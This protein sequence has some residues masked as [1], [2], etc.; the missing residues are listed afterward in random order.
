MEIVVVGSPE[1]ETRV[2]RRVWRGWDGERA[3]ERREYGDPITSKTASE[4][5]DELGLSR[6]GEYIYQELLQTQ[7]WF[8]YP[9]WSLMTAPLG[10]GHGGGH[11]VL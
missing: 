8:Q 7:V 5:K 2:P 3:T 1:R 4:V 10:S 9:P 6:Q 11:W